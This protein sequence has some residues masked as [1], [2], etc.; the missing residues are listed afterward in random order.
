MRSAGWQ[1]V[2]VV[3]ALAEMACGPWRDESLGQCS[4]MPRELGAVL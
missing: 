3:I 4:L 1:L 2:T